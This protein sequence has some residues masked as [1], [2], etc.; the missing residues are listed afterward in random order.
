MN[1]EHLRPALLVLSTAIALV[2]CDEAPGAGHDAAVPPAMDG[3]DPGPDAG[4][5][6]GTDAGPELDAAAVRDATVADR[7]ADGVPDDA[8]CDP[9]DPAVGA[10][11]SRACD[12]GCGAGTESCTDGVWGE[13][14]TPSECACATPGMRRV[15]TCGRCGMMSEECIEGRW[16]SVSMCLNQGECA[17]GDVENRSLPHCQSDQRLC[18]AACRW[19][20]WATIRPRGEC[21][22]GTM[23][24]ECVDYGG[25]GGIFNLSV[26]TCTDECVRICDPTCTV[27][28]R[29]CP[30]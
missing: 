9:D 7:D 4:P 12:R 21:E 30:R 24:T 1:L 17:V 26:W 27:A 15:V 3:G 18:D 28:S 25:P 5:P 2:A 6:P 20:A 16:Q 14:S 22:A 11:A 29:E 13:C 19:S 10:T 23:S 8:D